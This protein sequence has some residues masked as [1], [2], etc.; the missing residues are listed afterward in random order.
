MA[1]EILKMT[2]RCLKINSLRILVRILFG[3]ADFPGLKF[4]IIS[5]ISSFVQG[6]MKNESCLDGGRYSKNVLYQNGTSD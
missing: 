3:P 1:N 2:E 4:E 6:E 5:I